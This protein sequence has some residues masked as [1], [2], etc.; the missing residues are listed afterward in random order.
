DLALNVDN[1]FQ[2]DNCDAFDS[3]VDEAPTVQTMFMANFSSVDPVCDE[4]GPSYD[5][6]ILSEVHDHDH[7]Q[8]AVCE[9]HDEHEMHDNVQLNHV[10]D[11]HT[12]YTSNSNMILYDQY[13]KDN[14]MPVVETSLTAKLATYKE[15]VELYERRARTLKEH[16]EGIQKAL[17]KEMKD[18]FKELEAEVAQNSV[19]RKHDEIK[20]K[21]LLVVNDNLIAECLSKEVFYVATNSE[22]NVSRFTKMHVANTTVEAY[23]LEL[24]AELSN[25]RDKSHDDNHDE[26][27]NCFSNLEVHYLNL[28]LKYQNLKE[29]FRNNPPT[30]DKDTLDFDLVFVIGKMQAFL[31]GKED[32]IKKL[33]KQISHLQE[34][35]SKADR[36]Y[37]IDV[38]PI[39]FRRRNNREAHLDYLKHLKESVETIRDIVEEAKV[40]MRLKLVR[41]TLTNEIKKHAP[42]PLVRKKQV[43]FTKQ[44]DKSNS[45]THEHVAKLNTQKTNVPVPPS[46][47]VNRF[48]DASGSQP[49]SNTKKNRIS[50][51]KGVNKIQVEEQPRTNK[52]HLRTTNC[53]DSS[54]RSKSTVIQI[55]LWYLDSGCSKH[56][57]GDRSRLRNFVKKFIGTVRFGNDHFGVIMG[58]GDYMIGDSVIYRVYYM[59]GLRHKLFS[60]EQFYDSD[61][62]C[63]QKDLAEAV[64]TACYTQ[65]RSFI[66]TRHNKTPYELVH[67]K[68]PDLTFF[69]VFGALCYPTNDSEDLGKLQPT[70]DIGIFIS[71]APS[72]KD[73]F[74]ARTK[75]GSC[76]SLCTPTNKDLKILFQPMFDEYLEPPRVERPVSPALAVQ[77]PVNSAGTPS[78]TTIDQDAPSPILK[79]IYKVKLDEYDDVLKNKVRLVAKGYRQEEGIDFKESFA[80]VAHIEAIRIFIANATSKNMTIYQ[81]DVKT[82]FLNGELKEEVYVSQPESFV[83]PDH[84]THVYHLKKALYGLKHAPRAWYDTLLRFLLDNKFSKGEFDPTLFTR[85]T[86]K[87]I[88]LVQIYVDDIIF[89]LT[90]PKACDIFSN[91]MS[92][93]FQ[94]SMMGEMSFFLG[95]Q[96][97]QSPGGIFINQSKVALEVLKKFGM[98]SCDPVN[99]PMVDRL[100]LDEDPLGI[101]V[102]QTRFRSIVGSLMY[103]TA[104][105][106]DLVFAVCMCARYHASPTKKHLE[107]LKRVFWYLRET[108]NWG[109]W[110]PKDTAMALTAYADADHAGCQYT[111]RSTSESAQFLSDK[112]VSWSSKKQKS[113]AISTTEAEYIA[114]SGCCA[115]ILWMRSQ[116]TDYGFVFNKIPLYCDN[117]NAIALPYNNVQH[118]SKCDC[119]DT[120]VDVNVNAPAD[121]APTMAPPTHTDDQILPHIRW[122]TNFFRAFTASSTIPSIYIQQF[123]DTVRYDKTAKCYKCQLDE[124]WF[125]LTKDT[126]R[127]ALQITPVN[128][129]NAFSSPSSSDALINF[130]N[131]LGYLKV[132]RNLSNVVTNDM[133]QSWRALTIIINLCLTGKTSG[134]ERPRAPLDGHPIPPDE[135]DTVILPKCDESDLV[136][137]WVYGRNFD[138]GSSGKI[139]DDL[140]MCLGSLVKCLISSAHILL[141]SELLEDFGGVTDWYQE[142]SM[143]APPSPNHVFNFPE[144]EFEEDPQEEPEEEV[145]EDPKEDPKEEAKNDVPPPATLPVGSPITP[146]PLS[147]SLSD[148]EDD[149]P[150]I[151]NEALE[152][153]PVGSTYEVGGPSSVTPFP[154]FHMHGSEIAR[155]DG[156]TE[157]LLSN[158]QYLE[159]CEKKHKVDMET[160]SSKIR[161]GKKHMNKMEQGLGYEMQ[162]SSKVE[163][164]VTDVENREQERDEEMVKVKKHLGTLEANYSLVLSDRD[165]WRRAFLNLQA[166]VFERLG[167]GAWDARPGVGND[168]PFSFG[169]PK[170]PKPP[171][172]PSSSH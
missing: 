102:D 74:R 20:R 108:I 55:V 100:K 21:N 31:Q 35:R 134:F 68:K 27:L 66:H 97:S 171:G 59:E 91:E 54:S 52:S 127:D 80:P 125:D 103:L 77:A 88:L 132:I 75:S 112:L 115:Q 116:L 45:N 14:V 61:G 37:A 26:L 83:D 9:P 7:S 122:H 161:E 147:E 148:T 23:C 145:E 38:E 96:V 150:V 160:C 67:N 44:C 24:E 110:Y 104:S 25:L 95:L 144:A 149:A 167:W 60:V 41:M 47:G 15:Q 121:Q 94:M 72:R 92:S 162:F 166:L 4:A 28:Q 164:R 135:G 146:P 1:V 33:Q 107:A 84:P 39:P 131:D 73:K 129:N 11:T 99:T 57:T 8:D 2:T 40:N 106:P 114:M 81:M 63:I 109:L 154:P 48:T 163:H 140:D 79:W 153:P 139:H 133:F 70:A 82:A 19:D 30:P 5:S 128:N 152:M 34:T 172:S 137:N 159:R 105:R 113:I 143:D 117:R 156:N 157:L 87:H 151:E 136:M 126:L 78:S 71:Y 111:Q 76:S 93:K 18:V 69:K 119:A 64:A 101:P 22:L 62:S 3:D 50:P 16:F 118:S 49:R 65:N 42:P 12:D 120:M 17:T 123:W 29:S 43:T 32:I 36:K 124:Q 168:G 6:D 51:A 13:I 46:T 158:V 89:A 169:E 85:R 53:V 10:V 141:I 142:P 86:G 165:E 155:L 90:D 58:Y 170:P 98:D 130:V 138:L 56:M